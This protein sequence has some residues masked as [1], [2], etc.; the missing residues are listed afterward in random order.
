MIVKQGH[1]EKLHSVE[2]SN[3]KYIGIVWN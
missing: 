2:N 1:V 3:S